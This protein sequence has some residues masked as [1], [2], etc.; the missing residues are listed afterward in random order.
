VT[1]YDA[2]GGSATFERLVEA[3]YAGVAD[4][5]LL[6]PLYPEDLTGP[7]RHLTLFL[8]QYFGGP[9]TYSEERGHPQL[10]MRHQPFAIGPAERDAWLRH[11]AAALDTL[12][13]PALAKEQL[14]G[15][16]TGAANFLINQPA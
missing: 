14:R 10:R 4:D 2:V 11:M 12:E 5:P 7:R 15:Y 16:F 3:F 8:I 13:L 1:I 9:Q 6:R